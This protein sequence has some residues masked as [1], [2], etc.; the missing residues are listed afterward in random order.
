MKRLSPDQVSRIAVSL[1]DMPERTIVLLDEV[2]VADLDV[3][4]YN[5]NIYCLSQ[6]G[7]VLWQVE[8]SP[9]TYERDSFVSLSRATAGS[10]VA[11]RFFGNTYAID[12]VTGVA[13][14]IGWSK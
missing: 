10:L 9:S 5:A 7:E 12:Q 1:T 4:T 13:R 6:D 8:A 14:Q 2:D 11:R 3:A